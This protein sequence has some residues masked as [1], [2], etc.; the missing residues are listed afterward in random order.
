MSTVPAIDDLKR[1]RE[2]VAQHHPRTLL[3]PY[4]GLSPDGGAVYVKHEHH[5]PVRSFKGRGA[6][7]AMSQLS[8]EE[9]RRGVVTSSTGNHGQGVGWAGRRLGIDSIAVIPAATTEV[10]KRAMREHG[11]TLVEVD[12][13]LADATAAGRVLA[14]E[15]DKAFIDDGEDPRVMAGAATIAWE[16]FDEL[17]TP[18]VLLVPVGGGNLIAA[19]ALVARAVS[20]GTRVIGVQSEGAPAVHDSFLAGE[21]TWAECNTVAEGLATSVPGELAFSVIA[22]HV[23]DIVLVSDEEILDAVLYM[24][25]S[26]GQLLEPAAAAPIAALKRYPG[27]WGTGDIAVVLSGGH[28]PLER[29]HELLGRALKAV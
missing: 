4:P 28:I 14:R 24:L 19:L 10:K 5:G 27:A 25:E 13:N 29:L 3:H 15:E 12:G 8:R 11:V 6:L 22:E 17:R 7:C 21:V 23:D 9:R 26:A 1:A 18:D 20:P 2:I 16:I